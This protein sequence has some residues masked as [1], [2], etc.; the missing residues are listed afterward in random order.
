MKYALYLFLLILITAGSSS[1]KRETCPTYAESHFLSK[2]KYNRQIKLYQSGK[3]NKKLKEKKEKE[4]GN[5]LKTSKKVQKK[6]IP[7]D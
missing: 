5:A 3:L 7:K 1:C 2:K 4:N 6:P